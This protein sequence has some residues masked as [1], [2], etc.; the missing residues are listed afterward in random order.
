MGCKEAF[1]SYKFNIFESAKELF[2]EIIP[3]KHAF[4]EYDKILSR[5]KAYDKSVLHILMCG[6]TACVLAD[7]LTKAGFRALDLGHL[8]KHYDWHKRGIIMDAKALANFYAP[9]V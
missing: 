5:L 1:S 4:G 2:Y 7:D 3:N 6:P 9:D 8:A